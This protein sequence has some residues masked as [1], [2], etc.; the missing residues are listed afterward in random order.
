M[1]WVLTYTGAVFDFQKMDPAQVRIVDV[2]MALSRICRFGG[3]TSLPYSV[4]EHSCRM[5]DEALEQ[6]GPEEAYA[7]LMHDAP[8]YVLGDVVRPLKRGLPDYQ[9][10]ERDVTN[11]VNTK[12][13]V[14]VDPHVK[15]VVEGLDQMACC[16]EASWMMPEPPPEYA[17]DWLPSMGARAHEFPSISA[18][19]KFWEWEEAAVQFLERYYERTNK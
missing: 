6:Y 18:R 12:F 15:Q 13:K 17:N 16:F 5:H 11:L 19:P 14:S 4:A 8:E 1:S 7:C 10:I 2:A 9:A 3:H